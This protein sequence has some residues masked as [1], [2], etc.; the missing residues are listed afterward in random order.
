MSFGYQ[1]EDV[2]KQ[3]QWDPI[4]AIFL[5]KSVAWNAAEGITTL[6]FRSLE[7]RSH[8]HKPTHKWAGRRFRTLLPTTQNMKAEKTSV[9]KWKVLTGECQMWSSKFNCWEG[10][11]YPFHFYCLDVLIS[12]T[13]CSPKWNGLYVHGKPSTSSI[14]FIQSN[15]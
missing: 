5:P 3:M 6:N 15:E 8:R 4:K 9:K 12:H 1:A 11:R 7:D 13:C 14:N 10:C 2:C